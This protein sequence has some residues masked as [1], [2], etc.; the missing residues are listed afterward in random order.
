MKRKARIQTGIDDRLVA[1]Y[2]RK[3]RITN[4]GD[5]IGVQFKQSADYAINQLSLPEDYE[6]ARYEDKGLSGYYSDRPDFQRLLR[7][8]EMGKIKAV[9]CYKL[10]R[11]S[12]KT[13]DLMR[14][15]EYFERHDVTLLVCSN[16]INTR[17]STS[18]II[19]Q[20]LAIIAEFERDILTERIQDN[21]M[22]LAKDGRWLGGKTP[23]GFS[24][25]RVTTGSGKN[26]S[27]ISFLVPVQE[28][29]EI[30]L[31]I[32]G[33]FWETRSLLQTANIISEKY[34]TKHG[35]KFTTS[36]IRLILRNPIYCV[37]DEYSYNYFL[38]HDGNLFGEP[39]DFDGQHGLTAYNKT[40]QMKVED[41]D[42]TFFNPKFSQL[43]T[44]KPISEWIVSVGRH[45]G[46]ISSRKWVETQ[47]MLDEIAEKYNRPH[48]K[49]N[50]L[51]SGLMY[52]P[53][54]GKR[55]RVLPESNRWTNGKPRFKY[56]CP[57]VRAKECTFK[58]VEGVTLD[59]FVIHSLS[60][61]QEEH[62]DYYRQLLENRVASMIRTDQSEKEYQETKKA[63][64][65]LNAD[66]AAQVRNLREADDALKRFIQDDIKELTDELAKR[67]AALRRM[68]DT[69]SENQYLIHELNGMKKRLLSFEEFA[70]DAQPE[71][72]FTLVHSIVDRIYITTD[73]TKQKCQVYIKG[74]ATEDYS[75]VLGAAGYIEEEP[76]LPVVSYM[77]PMCDLDYYS[78]CDVIIKNTGSERG[79][80]FWDSAEMN[81]LKALV[82]YV[83]QGYPP[84]RKNIGQVYR[85]LTHC[86]EKE[87]NSLFNMLP[88]SHP[89]KAPYAIF[90][91][92]SD[93]VRSGVI[94]GLGSRLQ[95]FQNRSIC[96]M[97]AFDEID[98]ELPGQQPC[99]YFCITSDQDSTFDF[100][101][102]LFLSFVFI[103]LV[104]YADKNCEGGKL[105]IPVHVLGEELTAC[106]VIPD[107]SRKISVIRS[108]NISM[109]CVFQNL[110]GLQNRYPLNQWQEILGNSDVQLFLGCVDELTAKYISDRSGEVSVHVQSKAKQLGT[111]RISNYTPEYRETSGVGKRKLLTMD[112]VLRLPI[113][114]ALIIIRG[115]KLLQVDKCDY[116]KHPESKKMISCKASAHIPEWQKKQPKEV[117]EVSPAPVKKPGRK[118]RAP[119]SN[120]VPTDKDSIMSKN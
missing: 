21:L 91:Q 28:E 52:C 13:S 11:I 118:K 15:L 48:R 55:L 120:V 88:S 68:E 60:S 103:K 87:L 17:I 9:A 117:E 81:L 90:Q 27:A 33:T 19:I 7:D 50:A 116:T 45:E 75:D 92:A 79:D 20:V 40:D 36:T 63:I 18:K 78:I 31:E 99:A 35:A 6:F 109:S 70:K 2:A 98:M 108:R 106:G 74:C 39:S 61:L 8:I 95:V 100:L 96:N 82:L 85:L 54:C 41:E 114:K 86:D 4:K 16:N 14:L 5:S 59:E 23:T 10:D 93:T 102:S 112:E 67:E 111:W 113:S 26:K 56:A 97:T 24:S 77:P 107:L 49:T 101:S 57:G 22:E 84:E 12:R 80:H 83:E 43:L 30:V 69:Q 62:S 105:P 94:I 51:L 37:A 32:Y 58:G 89:A 71:A 73:G 44:R 64:E 47:N 3:S 29:K 66:I 34:E 65:R 72:L 104:R 115:R 1:I 42:S 110:A 53:I 76:L 25:Q 46:F 119:T 38:E